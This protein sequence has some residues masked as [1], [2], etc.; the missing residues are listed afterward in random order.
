MIK[1]TKV[2]LSLVGVVLVASGC[3]SVGPKNEV[4]IY[5]LEQK[6]EYVPID[7][8]KGWKC[9]KYIDLDGTILRVDCNL[10]TK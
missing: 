3:A 1:Y 8:T 2:S 10:V 4:V 6:T 9:L 5:Q 7:D